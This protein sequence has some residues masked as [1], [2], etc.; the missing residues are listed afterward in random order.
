MNPNTN[1]ASGGPRGGPSQTGPPTSPGRVYMQEKGVY[2]YPQPW[3]KESSKSFIERLDELKALLISL[4]RALSDKY[5]RCEFICFIVIKK[6]VEPM[7][8]G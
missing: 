2:V 1:H 3:Y 6:S 7:S 8:L 4:K 5:I